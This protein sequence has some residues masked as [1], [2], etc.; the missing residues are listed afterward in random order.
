MLYQLSYTR[1]GFSV[2]E[3]HDLIVTKQYSGMMTSGPLHRKKAVSRSLK[4]PKPDR[5]ACEQVRCH[6]NLSRDYAGFLTSV[7]SFVAF[8]DRN[9]G[10]SIFS[11]QKNWWLVGVSPIGVRQFHT[12]IP[13]N[14]LLILTKSRLATNFWNFC[15]RGPSSMKTCSV[16][17]SLKQTC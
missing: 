14:D 12:Q 8:Y 17:H 11:Q 2:P 13:Q 10:L 1:N 7:N 3:E 9:P 15:P 16:G 5:P 6:A 4:T